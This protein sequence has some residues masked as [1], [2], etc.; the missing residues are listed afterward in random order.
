MFG[1]GILEHLLLN[2]GLFFFLFLKLRHQVSPCQLHDDS[3]GH[4]EE[5]VHVGVDELHQ[6]RANRRKGAFTD[7]APN[8][9]RTRLLL[10]QGLMKLAAD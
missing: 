6:L 7:H 8:G 4:Y 5:K 9:N 2:A 3:H 10:C 1:F